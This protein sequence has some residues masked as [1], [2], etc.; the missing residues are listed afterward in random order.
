MKGTFYLTTAIDYVNAPPHLGHAYEKTT[1]DCIARSRRALG[2][3]VRFLIGNDEHGTKMEKS[4]AAAGVTPQEY[5]DRMDA[6]YRSTYEKLL[7]R[8]D[9]FIRTSEPRHHAAVN[10]RPG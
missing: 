3:D 10:T 4:A 1:A 2:W 9:E 7:V 6:V 5:V 8:W